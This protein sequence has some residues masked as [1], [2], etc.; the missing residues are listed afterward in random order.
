MKFSPGDIVCLRG[1]QDRLRR[2]ETV[3]IVIM[4]MTVVKDPERSLGSVVWGNP[5][6]YTTFSKMK[7]NDEEL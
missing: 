6:D 2:V 7:I 3:S 1:E 4:S 5:K